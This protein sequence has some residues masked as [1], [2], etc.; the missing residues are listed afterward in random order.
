MPDEEG[1]AE[2][3]TAGGGS[4][5]VATTGEAWKRSGR[6]TIRGDQ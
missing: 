2:G 1:V 5:L 6:W 3:R 4:H